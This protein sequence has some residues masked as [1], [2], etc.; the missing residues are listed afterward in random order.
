METKRYYH[1]HL[2]RVENGPLPPHPDVTEAE[3]LV[4]LAITVPMGHCIRDKLTGYWATTN[5]FHTRFY[6]SAMKRDR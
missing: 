4:F 5:Q 6:S 2:D 3:M 1:S